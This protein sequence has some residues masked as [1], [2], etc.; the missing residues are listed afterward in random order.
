MRMVVGFWETRGGSTYDVILAPE[1]EAT[2]SATLC[3][4]VECS[5]LH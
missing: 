3:S 2:E 4:T 5:R 1:L